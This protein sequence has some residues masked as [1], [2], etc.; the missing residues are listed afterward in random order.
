MNTLTNVSYRFD[1]NGS[2]S[3]ILMKYLQLCLH[4]MQFDPNFNHHSKCERLHLSYL[5][6]VDDVLLFSRGDFI[7]VEMMLKTFHK[8]LNFT[9][10][11]VNNS[12][13]IL[14]FGSF[15]PDLREDLI[16][17]TSF[18]EGTLPFKYLGVPITYKKL[19]VDQYLVFQTLD[20]CWEDLAHQESLLCFGQLLDDLL[21]PA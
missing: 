10:V 20:I 6:F 16:R 2:L 3:K 15:Q 19:S 11:K 5:M 12:K 9:G 14:Y 1:I 8:F 13:S 17:L 18:K 4:H 7:F 21:S